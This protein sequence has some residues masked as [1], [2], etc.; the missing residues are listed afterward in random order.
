[1]SDG[2]VECKQNIRVME[3]GHLRAQGRQRHSLFCPSVGL[4]VKGANGITDF[5][6]FSS[7]QTQAA[8]C[9]R[10]Y[11]PA[12]ILSFLFTMDYGRRHPPSSAP[13]AL[14][15]MPP[16]LLLEAPDTSDTLGTGKLREVGSLVETSV[17]IARASSILRV[18]TLTTL[19][20]HTRIRTRSRGSAAGRGTS[21]EW[22]YTQQEELGI[23]KGAVCQGLA[24]DPAQ[25]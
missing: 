9:V 16:S 8:M 24:C 2:Q 15:T 13:Q 12:S 3:V 18:G 4:V 19:I 6:Q 10:L 7:V 14:P 1:M 17:R 5:L 20:S 23:A 25:L 11:P 21:R 22:H